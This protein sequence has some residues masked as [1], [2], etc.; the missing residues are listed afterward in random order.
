MGLHWQVDFVHGVG[1]AMSCFG[2]A[3]IASLHYDATA[4]SPAVVVRQTRKKPL[5][6]D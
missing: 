1:G 3:L 4:R 2:G 5:F 6:N